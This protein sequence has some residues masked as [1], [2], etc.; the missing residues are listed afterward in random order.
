M[1][2]LADFRKMNNVRARVDETVTDPATAEAL[3]PWY[4]QFCKRPT[5]NDEYLPTFNRP[6]VTLVDTSRQPGRRADHQERAWSRT[7]SSTRSTASSSPPAS[8]SAPPG[9]GAP[10]STSSAGAAM[11]LTDYWADGLQTL[12]GLS[13]HGF[14]NCFF[15]GPVAERRFGEPDRDARR[16]GPA[17]RLHHQGGDGPRRS[18]L[19]PT[20]EAETAWVAEIKRLAVVTARFLAELHARLLQQRGPL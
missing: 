18:L 13:S 6:N 1:M 16:P 8:R 11:T 15:L 4:R 9:P 5:F 17:H 12:H 3:K 14:P 10:A 19:E 2:E 7:A 20:E